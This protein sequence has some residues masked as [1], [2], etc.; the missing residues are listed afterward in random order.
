MEEAALDIGADDFAGKPHTPMSLWKR[1]QRTQ[2]LSV[3][4]QQEQILRE[5]AYRDYLTGLL[6]RRG[7]SA[8]CQGAAAG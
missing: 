8:V 5:E 7:L 4:R 3:L 1:V 2:S 6:N